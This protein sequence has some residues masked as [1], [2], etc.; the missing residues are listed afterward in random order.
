MSPSSANV[1]K[2]AARVL[3]IFELFDELRRPVSINEVADCLGYPHSS[4]AAL[5]RS[6]ENLGYLEYDSIEKEFFPSIRISM[7]GHWIEHESLPVKAVQR[8]MQELLDATQCTVIAAIRSGVHVQYIKVLQGT[9]AIRYH[10][11]PGTRRLLHATTLGRVLL[12]QYD[13]PEAGRLLQQSMRRDPDCKASY[14]DLWRAITRARERGFAICTGLVV[15]GATMVGMPMNLDRSGRPAAVGLAAP[16]DWIATRRQEY[17]ALL[18]KTLDQYGM[19]A[20]KR[21]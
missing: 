1:V 3:E 4:A 6:L 8:L 12:S 10:V 14:D 15:P 5:L 16:E 18:R 13:S 9:T 20:E 7:L 21:A 17:L 11:K 2:S 19:P